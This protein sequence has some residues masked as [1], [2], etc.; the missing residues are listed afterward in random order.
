[1]SRKQRIVIAGAGLGGLCAALCLARQGFEVEVVERAPELAEV[2]AGIQISANAARV[3]AHLGLLDEL[4]RRGFEPETAEIRDGRSGFTYFRNRLRDAHAERY[5]FPYVQIHRADL[6][7]LL[8]TACTAAGI[9]VTIDSPVL[10]YRAFERTAAAVLISGREVEGDVLIGA[11]GIHSAVRMRMLGAE[12]PRFTGQVA[13]R[14]TIPAERL[15]RAKVAPVAGVWAGPGRH[16]VHYYLRGGALVNFVAIEE[17][18]RWD[19]ESWTEPGA[20]AELRQ[21]FAGWHETVQEIL[22]AVENTFL[23]GLFGRDRLKR[24]TDGRVALLGDACHP[25]LP[26]MAQGAAMAF[27]DAYVLARC[28]AGDDDPVAALKAYERL[29]IDRATRVQRQAMENGRLFHARGRAEQWRRLAPVWLASHVLPGIARSRF[30][31]LY[32]FDVTA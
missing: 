24:W 32:G 9:A 4:R 14:G 27:E 19:R 2:G 31:W 20:V 1:M 28:L 26:F 18:P 8:L 23:W 29:R 25:M 30:D 5:G 13:W 15:D 16:F 3:I 17:R 10:T 7:D 21:A 22:G 6:H 11:D 12:R